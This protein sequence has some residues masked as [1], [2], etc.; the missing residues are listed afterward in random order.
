MKDLILSIFPGIDVLG[1][2]F[3]E[4]GYCVVR[5][6]DKLWGGDI[7]TFHPPAGIFDGIIGGPPCQEFSILRRPNPHKKAKWGNLIPEFERVV[8]EAQPEWFA[9]ENVRTA[10]IPNIDGYTVNPEP[11]KQPVAGPLPKPLPPLLLW[12]QER[13][14]AALPRRRPRDPQTGTAACWPAAARPA[15]IIPR[16]T[17]PCTSNQALPTPASARP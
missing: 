17:T 8:S 14:T 15:F 16:A 6:P 3:E 2:A 7:R 5:G 4:Q 12:H 13:G 9:M 11:A 10:P 1:R